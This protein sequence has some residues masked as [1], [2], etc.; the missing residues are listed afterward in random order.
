VSLKDAATRAASL[1]ALAD[2][3]GAELKIAKAELQEALKAAKEETGTQQVG[4][5]LPGG[6]D[7]GKI[8]L[9]QPKAAAVV[10][11]E[12][13]FREWVASVRPGEVASRVVTEVRPAWSKL[14]LAEITAAE[15]VQWCDKETGELHDVPGVEFQG[16][17]SYTRM[18]LSDDDRAAIAEAWR[19]GQLNHLI[20]PQLT[21]GGAE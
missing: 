14:V 12:K 9:V 3:I 20:L 21:Q 17:A 5:T 10:T 8:S 18:T 13:A 4:V 6:Q 2:A 15:V 1:S 16:R 11:D 19:A 7:A